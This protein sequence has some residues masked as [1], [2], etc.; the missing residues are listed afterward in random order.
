MTN[1]DNNS[2][3]PPP[4]VAGHLADLRD[5]GKL[6]LHVERRCRVCR[7]PQIRE[8]VNKLLAHGHS[9]PAIVAL[10]EPLNATR[11][12][13]RQITKACVWKHSKRHFNLQAPTAAIWRRILKKRAAES[14]PAFED[15]V[16]SLVNA[17]S[18]FDIMMRKGFAT[19]VGEDT[20]VSPQE[21]AWAAKQLHEVTKQDVGV[22]RFAQLHQLLDWGSS[23]LTTACNTVGGRRG[24][25]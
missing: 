3:P 25:G 7:D 2:C 22:E 21:G 10:L 12:R 18:Y 4:A 6:E 13:N 17:A 15:G 5:E 14:R 9:Y 19:M 1:D 20:V 16:A 24:R 8:L 11:A 23:A